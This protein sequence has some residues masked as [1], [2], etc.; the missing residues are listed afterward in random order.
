MRDSLT[1]G[2]RGSSKVRVRGCRYRIMRH[3]VG[4][5]RVGVDDPGIVLRVSLTLAEHAALPLGALTD[6]MPAR[7]G[8][9]APVLTGAV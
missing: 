2:I 6:H 1:R 9:I 4:P 7:S 8:D 5:S 3:C